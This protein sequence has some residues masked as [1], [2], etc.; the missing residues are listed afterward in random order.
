MLDDQGEWTEKVREVLSRAQPLPQLAVAQP[1]A[2]AQ[3]AFQ[4]YEFNAGPVLVVEQ[5]PRARAIREIGRITAWHRGLEHEV[6]RALDA[7]GVADL[8]SLDDTALDQLLDRMR[9]LE[10]NIYNGGDSPDAPAAR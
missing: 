7:A 4:L 3:R 2:Q 5:T 9:L 8:A 10:D 6:P 1:E